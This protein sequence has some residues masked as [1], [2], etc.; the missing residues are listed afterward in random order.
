MASLSAPPAAEGSG[1]EGSDKDE[2]TKELEAYMEQET[3]MNSSDMGVDA[4]EEA[5]DHMDVDE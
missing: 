5:Q 2:L 4:T 1:E 3:G